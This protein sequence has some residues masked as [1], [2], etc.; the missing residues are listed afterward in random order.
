[1]KQV[2][3]TLFSDPLVSFVTFPEGVS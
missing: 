1:M 2:K 3:R